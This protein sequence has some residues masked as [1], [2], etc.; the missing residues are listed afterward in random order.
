[1]RDDAEYLIVVAQP[2][3]GLTTAKS[4]PLAELSRLEVTVAQDRLSRPVVDEA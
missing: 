3:A 2:A 1:M 4:L